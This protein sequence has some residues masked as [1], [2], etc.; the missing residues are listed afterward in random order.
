M[1]RAKKIATVEERNRAKDKRIQSKFGITLADRN[2]RAEEQNHLCKIC[3]GQLERYG[4]AHLDHFHF[5]VSAQRYLNGPDKGTLKIWQADGFD[6]HREIICTRYA[7]TRKQAIADVKK[8]MMPWS[9]RALLCSKC[10]RGLGYV[11]R[12]FGAARYPEILDYIKMYLEA[13]LNLPL[14][15]L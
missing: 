8:V 3:G 6:E 2:R 11:E 13:R 9:I 15:K 5:F 12:F 4:P 7:P 1:A 14:T 10:N